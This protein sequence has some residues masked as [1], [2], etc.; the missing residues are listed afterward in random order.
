MKVYDTSASGLT[1]FY[2]M[3]HE[4]LMIGDTGEIKQEQARV[5]APVPGA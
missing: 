3:S 4:H 2:D 1:L 5:D